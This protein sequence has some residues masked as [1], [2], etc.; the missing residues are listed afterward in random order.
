MARIRAKVLPTRS[1]AKDMRFYKDDRCRH[2]GKAEETI[3]HLFSR[4]CSKI[5]YD[6]LEAVGMYSM[7]D[8]YEHF[9]NFRGMRVRTVQNAVIRFV[10]K[11][12]LFKR[13]KPPRA[14]GGSSE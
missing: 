1:W 2:C 10:K 9:R 7:E 11:N 14:G 4:Q 12:K 5:V 3:D 8:I 13:G 6:E